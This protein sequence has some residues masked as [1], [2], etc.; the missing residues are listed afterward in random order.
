M[1]LPKKT[2]PYH[3]KDV[4]FGLVI[5]VIA[6]SIIASY[7]DRKCKAGSTGKTDH[8]TCRRSDPDDHSFDDKNYVWLLNFYWILYGSLY[9]C[10]GMCKAVW[11]Q[12]K[13]CTAV[14]RYRS[15][16]FS[17]IRAQ[18]NTGCLILC[19]ISDES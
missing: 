15:D 6:I 7:G 12:C 14:D 17:A 16:E 18:Q 9:H 3:L 5:S 8:R 2:K 11:N 13:W 4:K 1:R 19:K 10:T